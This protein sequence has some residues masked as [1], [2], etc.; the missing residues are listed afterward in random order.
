MIRTY[1]NA[2]QI[3]IIAGMRSMMAPA[4]VS[5]KLSHTSFPKPLADSKLHFLVSPKATMALELMAGGELIGDKLP[6]AGDRTA[7]PQVWGRIVSGALSGAALTEA[8]EQPVVYGAV[9]GALGAAAGTFAF[10]HLRHWLTHEK[11]VPDTL[12]AL[13]EDAL[14]I[15]AGL[16]L[17][18][19]E[20]LGSLA[21]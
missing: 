7:Q 4:F 18:N 11:N 3:G 9:L 17:I 1:I 13:A 14:A 20:K 10:F 5:Y 21:S 2:F 6:N 15:G 19:D 12:V 16:V 8:D